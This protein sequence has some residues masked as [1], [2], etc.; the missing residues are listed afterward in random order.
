MD[1]P[2]DKKLI[3]RERRLKQLRWGIGAGVMVVAVGWLVSDITPTIN[4]NDITVAVTDRGALDVAV[5]AS[6]QIVPAYEEIISSPVST[7]LLKAFAQAGDTVKAG[8]PLLE[9]DLEK[10]QIELEKRHEAL[11]KEEQSLRQMQLSNHTE[12][13]DLEMRIKVSEMNLNRLKIEVANERRLDSIGSGTGDRV[14][15]AET[16]LSSGILELQQLRTRLQNERERLAAAER[17]QQLNVSSAQ[18]EIAFANKTI[19]QGSIPAPIDGV[20]T[21]IV[22]E[23]GARIS[24]GEKVAVVSDLTRFKINGEVAEGLSEKV[25]VGSRV[26]VRVNGAQ[27]TGI[28]SNITPQANQGAVSFVVSLDN[29]SESHLRSG[30]RAE[31]YV[32]YAYKDDVLRLRN[33]S[34]Y[35]GAGEYRLF[36]LDGSNRLVKRTVH[37]GGSNREY[38]EITD[39]LRE[40]DR[41]VVSD[42]QRYQ[43]KGKLKIK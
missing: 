17:S 28:V 4:S 42:M 34:Y 22:S 6:G 31:L 35:T 33:G 27:L 18:R 8:M 20:L 23:P 37:A 25:Q 3:R 12:L 15:Q 7:R 36:V 16:A 41:V 40:G 11:I 43:N 10:E 38:V 26:N 21:F 30:G 32:L 29:P 9:L 14:R 19:H 39:G 24:S 2:I 13:S 1:K 5:A